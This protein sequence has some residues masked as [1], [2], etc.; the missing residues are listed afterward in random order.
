MHFLLLMISLDSHG[1]YCWNLRVMHF[2]HS[3]IL[4]RDYKT[5]FTITFGPFVVIMEGNF[6]MKKSVVFVKNSEF[7]NFYAPKTPQQNRVVE[8]KNRSLEE[9]ARTILRESFLQKYF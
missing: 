7:S 8:R 4:P 5:Y 9:L 2:Q 3:K 1:H 6:K